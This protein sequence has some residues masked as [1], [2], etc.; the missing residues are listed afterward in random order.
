MTNDS[1]DSGFEV[2]TLLSSVIPF[3]NI[4]KYAYAQLKYPKI[5]QWN[6]YSSL[7]MAY[8]E[9]FVSILH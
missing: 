6:P 9:S 7:C 1:N 5:I 4:K 8:Y 3:K 2:L